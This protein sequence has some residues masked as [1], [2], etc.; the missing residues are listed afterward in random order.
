MGKSRALR[1]FATGALS[2]LFISGMSPAGASSAN[3]SHSYK[4][5][6][7]ITNGSIVSLDSTKTDY[8]VP[9]NSKNGTKLLGVS[10]A[11]DDSLLAVDPT[12]GGVQVAT[13]GTVNT[14][15]STLNGDIK[16]GD[17]ISVSPFNGVGMKAETGAHIIGLAQN[18]L[19]KDSEG[20]K[21]QEVT[22][23]DGKRGQVAIGF[24][25]LSI[26]VGTVTQ[27]GVQLNSLQR[28]TKSLTGRAV[29]TVKIVVSLAIAVVT[30]VSLITLIY[31]SIFGGIISIGRNPLAKFA[32]FRS[33]GSVLAMAFITAFVAGAIIFLILR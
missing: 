23:K 6:S 25:R 5:S 32:I 2:A 13:S 12:S 21:L 27:T 4:S 24:I 14:L 33:I 31:A 11:S 10:L 30:I 17:Q 26:S 20:V 28:I 15:V 3:I 8:V 7:Q 9:A 29:S 22:D 19:S 18:S 16:V 1:L